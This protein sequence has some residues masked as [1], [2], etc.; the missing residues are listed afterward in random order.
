MIKGT[1]F[2]PR[3]KL[4]DLVENAEPE[5]REFFDIL[6]LE[7]KQENYNSIPKYYYN[8]KTWL[9]KTNLKCW[10]CSLGV[11][12][13]PW[14]LP[15]GLISKSIN[16][17]VLTNLSPINLDDLTL[18][19]TGQTTEVV[20]MQ[21]EGNFCSP[22]CTMYYFNRSFSKFSGSCD[23]S[24]K[25][26]IERLIL[27]LYYDFVGVR[28]NQIPEAEDKVV[29]RQYCGNNGKTEEEFIKINQSKIGVQ[30]FI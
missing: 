27:D 25:G 30:P 18:P 24:K 9:N 19:Q 4:S 16:K 15:K 13:K 8:Y 21:V 28:V 3:L 17:M 7:V 10:T 20:L 2:L 29:M 14:F 5:D 26:D 1:V 6:E 11:V 23:Q 12:G 22:F